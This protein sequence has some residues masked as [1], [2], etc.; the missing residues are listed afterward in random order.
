MNLIERLARRVRLDSAVIK[1]AG[2]D[3]AVIRWMKDKYL[4]YTCDMLI[5]DVH[6]KLSE[7]AP[8]DIG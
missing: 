5:E 6:F 3:A 1:G 4:L 2:D 8:E 7:A